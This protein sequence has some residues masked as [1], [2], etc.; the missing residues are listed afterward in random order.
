[1]NAGPPL[2]LIH[3]FAED[4]GIWT[5]QMVYL[6]EKYRLIVPDLPGSGRSSVLPGETSMEEMAN[7]IAAILDAE[8]IGQAILVG[9]S[10]G[11]YIALAFVEEYPDRVRAF[12]L[13]HSTAFPDSE[14]KK[15][16]RR[17]SNEFIRKHGA[18]IFIQQSTPNLFTEDFRERHPDSVAETVSVYSD[19]DP[20][21]LIQYYNAMIR[22]PDRTEILKQATQPVLFVIGEKDST[23]PLEISLQ[24]SH[25]P[26]LS[27]IHILQKSGHMGMLEERLRSGLILEEFLNFVDAQKSNEHHSSFNDNHS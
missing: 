26:A 12:G 5:S 9:H 6:K 24:Q 27:S 16:M 22:R 1:M 10:M 17:K 2:V 20:N 19:F 25:M 8:G 18:A 15:A 11:G 7:G 13:F 23:L 21:S 3:G 4:S 14:E